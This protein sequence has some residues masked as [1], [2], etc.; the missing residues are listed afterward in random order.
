MA[1]DAGKE[2][3]NADKE[4]ERHRQ[5]K[6]RMKV[7]CSYRCDDTLLVLLHLPHTEKERDSNQLRE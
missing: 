5:E 4:K 1:G 3:K 6:E 7:N 2:E